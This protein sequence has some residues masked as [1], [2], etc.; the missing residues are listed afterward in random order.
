MLANEVLIMNDGDQLRSI[1]RNLFIIQV[2]MIV[3]FLSLIATGIAI[4]VRW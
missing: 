3:I 1:K 4:V 2:S